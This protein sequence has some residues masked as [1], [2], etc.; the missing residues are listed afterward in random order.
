MSKST[1]RLEKESKYMP[2]GHEPPAPTVQP[3]SWFGPADLFLFNEG[4][5]LKLYERLGAHPTVVDGRPGYH[6]AVWAPNADYVAVVADFNNWD[7]FA[8]PM[9]RGKN[10]SSKVTISLKPGQSYH[11][12]YLLDG[13]RWENDR[14]ADGL[15][16][17]PFGGEDSLIMI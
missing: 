1:A 6:F 3:P 2:F 15:V 5:H 8:N 11:F 16:P 4:S 10:G 9:A 12:R 13:K 17:N 14:E 7:P